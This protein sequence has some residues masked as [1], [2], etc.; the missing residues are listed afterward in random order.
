VTSG[1]IRVDGRDIRDV[2]IS[3]LR[4]QIGVVT[5]ET[6]LFNDTLRNNIAYGQPG[7]SQ[8]E[9]ESAARAALAHDFI[10]ELPAGYDTVIGEKGVRL[11]GGER[12]RIAIARALLKNAPILV[13][14]EATSALDSESE[15]LVQ[16]A[17]QNLMTGRTVIVIAHRLSTVRR[18]DRI[19]VLENGTIAEVGKHEELMQ[20]AGIYR[21]LYDLQ[22]I[23]GDTRAVPQ[24]VHGAETY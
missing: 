8:A 3:S 10:M 12:Q 6:V 17:L 24:L 14:D 11:S 21:K 1:F 2:T 9:V 23:D 13:L 5:Q 15:A 7:V 22:F 20:K 19:V 18:A 4:C 16:S